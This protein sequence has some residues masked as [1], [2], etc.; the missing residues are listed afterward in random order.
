MGPQHEVNVVLSFELSGFF[1]GAD[2]AGEGDLF[3]PAFAFKAGQFSEVAAHAVDGV[4][5]YVARVEHHEVGVFVGLYLSVAGVQDHAPHP[6]R[7]VDV[8]LAAERSY[9]R[10]LGRA[11]R[12]GL[13]TAGPP[14]ALPRAP[15]EPGGGVGEVFC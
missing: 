3:H 6:V 10:S 7:V 8:H 2:T 15:P 12:A 13:W 9:A 5:S 1:G 14:A 11:A 4:L